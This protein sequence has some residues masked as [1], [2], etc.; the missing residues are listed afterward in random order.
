MTSY[1]PKPSSAAIVMPSFQALFEGAGGAPSLA[2]VVLID[3][4][5]FGLWV[6]MPLSVKSIGLDLAQAVIALSFSGAASSKNG[7]TNSAVIC[8]GTIFLFRTLSHRPTRQYGWQILWTKLLRQPSDLKLPP[9]PGGTVPF[10]FLDRP[11]LPRTIV[12]V[13]ILAQGVLR[14]IRRSVLA[15]RDGS[16]Q[17]SPSAKRLDPEAALSAQLPRRNSLPADKG[18]DPSNGSPVEARAPST[19]PLASSDALDRALAGKRKKKQATMV[20]SLQ[21]FWAALAHTKV[22]VANNMEQNHLAGDAN[23]AQATDINHIGNANFLADANRVWITRLEATEIGFGI[24]LSEEEVGQGKAD[25]DCERSDSFDKSAPF[26][27]R[28]NGANWSSTRFTE[29]AGAGVHRSGQLLVWVGE[30]FGLTPLCNY[31]CEFVRMSDDLTIYKASLITQPALY[32]EQGGLARVSLSN[33]RSNLPTAPAPAHQALRPSSPTTTLK[34]SIA[35]AE[36]KLQEQRNKLKRNRKDH[37]A[38]TTAVKKEVD[39]LSSGLASAGGQDERLK[40][41]ATQLK[42]TIKQAEDAT[43]AADAEAKDMGEI[44]EDELDEHRAQKR[45]WQKQLDIQNAKRSDIDATKAHQAREYSHVE[46]EIASAVQKRER[47]QLRQAKLNEQ[48]DRIERA[49]AQDAD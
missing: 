4:I 17:M 1:V 48:H 35:A 19:L 18:Q 37:K 29:T 20:R 6:F 16:A 36:A 28:I 44:P 27:V 8:L 13:H 15:A 41:R 43:T 24:A 9:D 5:F 31:V 47:L 21:P 40:Q 12:G 42:Q 25:G 14:V 22:T 10:I 26:Y 38:A 23:E 2:T 45:S 32:T 34:N 30:I 39:R 49:N 7:T 11:S 3:V 33:D 46:A